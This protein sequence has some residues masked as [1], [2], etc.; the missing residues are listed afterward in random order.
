MKRLTFVILLALVAAAAFGGWTQYNSPTTK[1]INAV[2]MVSATEAWS[3]GYWGEILRL[4][5]GT[6]SIYYTWPATYLQDVDFNSPSWGIA[7]GSA[8]NCCTY[9]GSSWTST[10]IPV[11][12][13][14]YAVGLPPNQTTEA[15]A[16]GINANLWRWFGGVWTKVTLSG[17]N[18]RAIHDIFWTSSGYDGWLVGD[19][20][21]C[22]HNYGSGWVPVNILGTTT[23][24]YCIY[25]LSSNN[26][27]V[28]GSG[29]KLYHWE[30]ITWSPVATPTNQAIREMAFTS[31]TTGWAVCDG[32]VVIKYNG[33]SWA[34]VVI[35]PSSPDSFSGLNLWDPNMGWAVGANGQI[36]RYASDDSVA[37]ASLGTIKALLR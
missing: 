13:D 34:T 22:Y 12:A 37:P 29:G 14:F 6:W 36:Y 11:N 5:E 1:D 27:W 16:G 33:V 3:V 9:N 31:P 26:V 25:A 10:G 17:A 23:S 20:G 2:D 32:G 24:F 8:G 21:L 19:A 15:W 35:S 4:S 30:G 28:G 18:N 7:V